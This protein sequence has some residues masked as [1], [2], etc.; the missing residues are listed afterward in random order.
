MFW[1][2]GDHIEFELGPASAVVSLR[3]AGYADG[4]SQRRAV[5][6][7]VQRLRE[8]VESGSPLLLQSQVIDAVGGLHESAQRETLA[9]TA[10]AVDDTEP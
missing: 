2:C 3:P 1:S 8:A 4:A 6:V 9:V 10:A 7:A 5:G